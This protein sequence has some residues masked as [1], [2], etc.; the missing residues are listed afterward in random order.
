MDKI[1]V[2]RGKIDVIDE[3]ILQAIEQRM[4]IC[5]AIG[6]LKKQ[7]DKPIYDNLREAKVFRRVKN[8]AEQLKLDPLQIERIYREIVNMC[9]SVQQ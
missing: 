4:E 6:E 8:H 9:S 7:Q 1:E 5:R 3:Q 2:L